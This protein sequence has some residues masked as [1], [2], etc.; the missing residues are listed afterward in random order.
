LYSILK[1][2][3]MPTETYIAAYSTNRVHRLH[4]TL[5]DM[6]LTETDSE[7]FAW[8]QRCRHRLLDNKRKCQLADWTTCGLDILR[9]GQLAD[10]TSR[11]SHRWLCV[12]SF[13][14]SQLLM[15]SCVCTYIYVYCVNCIICPQRLIMQLKQQVLLLAASTIPWLVRSATC[16]VHKLT[17]LRDVQS[18]SCQS[19]S[20]H[21][22]KLS[23]YLDIKL[24]SKWVRL[25]TDATKY[26]NSV[27]DL[28]ATYYIEVDTDA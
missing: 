12:L 8:Q 18:T 19:A 9:T 22:F 25:W 2:Q 10:W 16:P 14:F 28:Q 5:V 6:L 23:Y 1:S 13:H 17:S 26:T 3:D 11:G 21:I 7:N 15:F 20:W 24:N 27:T 4:C